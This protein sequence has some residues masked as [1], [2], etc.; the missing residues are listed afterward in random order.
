MIGRWSR[1]PDLPFFPVHTHVLPTGKVMIW[2]GD[3]GGQPPG[4]SGNDPRLWDPATAAV[5]P[6][7]AAWLRCFLFWPCFPGGWEIVCS[8]RAH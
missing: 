4:V 7:T 6:L 8:R 3:I 1:V 5:S 2:P